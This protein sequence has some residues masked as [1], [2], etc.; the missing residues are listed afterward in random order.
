MSLP[1]LVELKSKIGR[2]PSER[3]ATPGDTAWMIKTRATLR[4]ATNAI[5]GMTI[6]LI[7][8][9]VMVFACRP[10][11]QLIE[12]IRWFPVRWSS[13]LPVPASLEGERNI[14]RS[15]ALFS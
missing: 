12:I 11:R 6:R 13:I 4:A 8:L 10:D 5:N 9:A 14:G 3:P 7:D 1:D 2:D 15:E